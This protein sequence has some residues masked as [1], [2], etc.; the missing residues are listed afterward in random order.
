MRV[1]LGVQRLRRFHELVFQLQVVKGCLGC[2]AFHLLAAWKESLLV[3][4]DGLCLQDGQRYSRVT[5]FVLVDAVDVVQQSLQLT[6]G[7]LWS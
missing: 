5:A 7:E 4:C 1:N 6:L 3:L 2:R